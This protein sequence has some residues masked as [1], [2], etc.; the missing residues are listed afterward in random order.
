MG[1]KE[2]HS[3][4][5]L[6]IGNSIQHSVN[7]LWQHG[8]SSA[9]FHGD[10]DS[11]GIA[12]DVYTDIPGV[13]I[14]SCTKKLTLHCLSPRANYTDW[15][16]AAS[17]R[18]DCQ[19]FA[20]RRCHV[21]SVTDPSGRISGFSRQEPLLFYQVAPQFVLTRLSGPRSRPTKFFFW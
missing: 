14:P 1:A 13:S 2:N 21:V 16:T 17:R 15:A 4:V 20:D 3:H 6:F 10:T 11:S 12:A 7:W 5:R 19:L 8:R 9:T 18:R